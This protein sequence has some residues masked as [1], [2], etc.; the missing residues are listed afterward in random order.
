MATDI[1]KQVLDVYGRIDVLVNNAG[2]CLTGICEFIT[3]AQAKE[4]FEVNFFGAHRLISA[5]LP[6]MRAQKSG[7]I[8]Q[9]LTE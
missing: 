1:V 8:G 9:W 5:V 7:T 6:A 4:Q 3:D 2:T